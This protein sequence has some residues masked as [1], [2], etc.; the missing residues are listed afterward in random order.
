[1]NHSAAA[2]FVPDR[3]SLRC[4]YRCAAVSITSV[5]LIS[6]LQEPP[7]PC[8]LSLLP[9]ARGETGNVH[10]AFSSDVLPSSRGVSAPPPPRPQGMLG[11]ARRWWAPSALIFINGATTVQNTNKNGTLLNVLRENAMKWEPHH[12]REVTVATRGPNKANVFSILHCR[13]D[14]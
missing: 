11:T 13:A 6:C 8:H 4:S 1:M 12:S 10:K 2:A 9:H 5:Q 7:F 14:F 3:K